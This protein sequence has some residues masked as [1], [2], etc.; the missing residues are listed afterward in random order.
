MEEKKYELKLSYDELVRLV[1]FYEKYIN[2]KKVDCL[3]ILSI[4]EMLL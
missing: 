3:K 4:F 1:E 2:F